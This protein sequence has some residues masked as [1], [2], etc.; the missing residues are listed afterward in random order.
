MGPLLFLLYVNDLPNCS[1]LLDPI[2]FADDTNLFFKHKNIQTLFSTVN[3][4]LSK[5]HQWFLS[6]KLSLNVKKTKYSL[7]H[8]VNKTDDIPLLLP[9]LVIKNNEI[10]RVESIKFL[11]VLLDECMSW[12]N[13]INHIENKISKSIGL[14]YRAKS[15][16]N[17]NSLLA[18]YYLYIHTYLN[19]GNI[20]WGSSNKTNLA[21]LLIQQKHAIRIINNKGRF[22]HTSELFKAQKILNIFKL[23]I[24]NVSIFMHKINTKTAPYTFT[25]HFQRI[26]HKYPTKYS[27]SNYK[28]PKVKLAKTK[29]RISI[30]GP[31]IWNNFISKSEKEI[32]SLLLFKSRVKLKLLQYDNEMMF[33]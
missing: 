4:E 24:F 16:L 22:E 23:N 26:V 25:Q 2:M 28:K 13:H 3:R 20:V 12:K 30:R 8:K 27:N 29:F 11:G 19:Y 33:F 17:K 15:Y 32:K 7:F 21:K 9:K 31:S 18:L 14:L 5:I 6:N 10:E 1:D